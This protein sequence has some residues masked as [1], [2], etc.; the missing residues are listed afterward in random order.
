[1]LD[2]AGDHAERGKEH[3]VTVAGNDLGRD[4]LD[5]ETEPLG[6]VR[7]DLGSDVGES[8]DRAAYRAGGDLR[9]RG[10]EPRAAA[11]E[12][13]VGLRQLESD[14]HRFGWVVVSAAVRRRVFMVQ[15]KAPLLSATLV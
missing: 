12:L 9:E 8:A 10:F 4:R 7:F 15:D 3:R 11:R 5:G 6:D 14:V 1:T 13:G 2:R